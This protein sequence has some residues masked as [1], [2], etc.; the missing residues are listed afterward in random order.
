MAVSPATAAEKPLSPSSFL[1]P[2]PSGLLVPSIGPGTAYASDAPIGSKRVVGERFFGTVTKVSDGDTIWVVSDGER[3]KIRIAD[4]DAPE[5]AQPYGP[6]STRFLSEMI[7]GKTVV[8][9]VKEKD[10]Y[11]RLV[12]WIETQDG[13]SVNRTM[14]RSGHAWWYRFFSDD[15]GLGVLERYARQEKRGL[16]AQ[17]DPEAPWDYR[18]RMRRGSAPD[19][20]ETDP[21]EGPLN[22][23]PF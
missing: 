20:W 17:E 19:P 16:W 8:V 3:S 6:A 2:A 14:I 21:L 18:R 22:I 1:A 15:E 10:R 11:G 4:T 5:K 7:Y 13:T 23:F 12:A 9:L